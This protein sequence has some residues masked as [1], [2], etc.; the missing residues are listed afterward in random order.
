MRVLVKAKKMKIKTT[1]IL[2]LITL[3]ITACR[4]DEGPMLSF[5][6]VEKRV[7][8]HFILIEFT[9]E[10]SD[11]TQL[12]LDSCGQY[13]NFH[14][15]TYTLLSYSL[16]L[17]YDPTIGMAHGVA[18]WSLQNKNKEIQ[19]IYNDELGIKP[20]ENYSTTIWKIERLTKQEMWLSTT[21]NNADYYLKL[22]ADE[23]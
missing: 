15:D 9:E 2:I 20:F 19:I 14:D 12:L 3:A 16:V 21:Y 7:A 10:D 5:R 13:W 23:D 4:Y 8:Q 11:M 17:G 6:S 1:A 18:E 22:E